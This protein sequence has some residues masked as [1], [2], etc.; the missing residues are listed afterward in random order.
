MKPYIMI[1]NLDDNFRVQN[2]RVDF[3]VARNKWMKFPSKMYPDA[4]T[5]LSN[6]EHDYWFVK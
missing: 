5:W 3:L 2:G 1:C 4:E 6:L